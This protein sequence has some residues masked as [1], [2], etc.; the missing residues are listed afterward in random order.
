[1]LGL[2]FVETFFG[3]LSRKLYG[4]I[5]SIFRVIFPKIFTAKSAMLNREIKNL[6]DGTSLSGLGE[7]QTEKF[8]KNYLEKNASLNQ[9]YLD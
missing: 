4:I 2:E 7:A 6:Q 5:E 3:P 9:I 8:A 1:V